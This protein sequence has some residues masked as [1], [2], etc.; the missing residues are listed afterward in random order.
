MGMNR[1][2]L[3]NTDHLQRKIYL[4]NIIGSVMNA[5]ASVFLLF[6]VTRISGQTD[7]GIFSLAF[8]TAQMMLTIGY[9]EM[10]AFQAT[11]ITKVYSFS[12]YLMS[13]ILTCILMIVASVF[14]VW[15]SGYTPEKALI[16]VLVCVFKMFDALE[17][18]F[19][20]LYQQNGRLDVAG[21]SLALRVAT[22]MVAFI[23]TLLFTRNLVTAC[24]VAIIAA[25]VGFACFNLTVFRNF[26]TGKFSWNGSAIKKLL[27]VCFPLF[28]GSFMLLYINN[29]PKYAIDTY[30]PA[31]YFQAYFN[32]LFMP[33][34]VINLFSTFIF[35]PM[36]TTMAE[37][38]GSNQK[39][40]LLKI[41]GKLLLAV[42][43]LTLAVEAAGY[44]LG[45]PVLSWFYAADLAQYRTELLIL[46]LGGGF[47]AV[48]TLMFYGITVLRKQKFVLI[49]YSVTLALALVISAVLV[50]VGGLMGASIAYLLSM[51]I[52]AAVFTITFAVCYRKGKREAEAAENAG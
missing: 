48:V 29:A 51:V 31:E 9:Y 34:F 25:A 45:I 39:K 35:K 23:L 40:L 14:F 17:D 37:V 18:V 42:A 11:D 47:N 22:S 13:R 38:W 50:P 36:V 26:F 2:L 20:G 28:L 32:Y 52:L 7:A 49:G 41:I 8:S 27:W 21:K 46:I 33:A 12:D 30:M 6:A 3:G 10:R 1:L 16:V 24:A 4:W 15:L 19:H 43:L 5:L 44:F